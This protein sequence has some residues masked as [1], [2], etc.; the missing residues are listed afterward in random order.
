MRVICLFS[1]LGPM[2]VTFLKMSQK[3]ISSSTDD[4]LARINSRI[5]ELELLDSF[6]NLTTATIYMSD[7]N[8]SETDKNEIFSRYFLSLQTFSNYKF[9]RK[10]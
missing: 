8:N 5:P 3:T 9:I 10:H 6:L 7:Q 2:I 1:V 4:M